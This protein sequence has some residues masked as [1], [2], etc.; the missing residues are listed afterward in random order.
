MIAI[1]SIAQMKKTK[2]STIRAYFREWSR[3]KTETAEEVAKSSSEHQ[4]WD[5]MHTYMTK[6]RTWNSVL[7]DIKTIYKD[8][9]KTELQ[10]MMKEELFGQEWMEE[11]TKEITFVLKRFKVDDE[12]EQAPKSPHYDSMNNLSSD[13]NH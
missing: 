6:A 4:H 7:I 3:H 2:N 1:A 13:D 9:S 10:R 11:E 12:D 8:K 5:W